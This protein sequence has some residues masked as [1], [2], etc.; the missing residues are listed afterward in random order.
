M[1]NYM[2][3]RLARLVVLLSAVVL[4][5]DLSAA[6]LWSFSTTDGTDTISGQLTTDGTFA[7]L[8][9]PREFVV[10]S[11]LSLSLNGG[12]TLFATDPPWVHPTSGDLAGSKFP[13][14]GSAVQNPIFISA[15][16]VPG[17]DNFEIDINPALGGLRAR[18][19]G[20]I[21]FTPTSTLISP[22][23]EPAVFSGIFGVGVL[24]WSWRHRRRTASAA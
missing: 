1:Q 8:A 14:D 4:A 9:G 13:W 19:D 16:S 15:I 20:Q 23:P 3:L 17:G 5:R 6:I 12:P 21:E 24:L 2:R 11:I 7:D 22:I 18:I 10:E